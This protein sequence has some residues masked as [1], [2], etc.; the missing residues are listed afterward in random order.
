MAFKAKNKLDIITGYEEDLTL[1]TNAQPRT[2][3]RNEEKTK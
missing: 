2:N 3:K 1:E